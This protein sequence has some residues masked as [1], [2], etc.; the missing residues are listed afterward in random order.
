[1]QYGSVKE[2]SDNPRPLNPPILGDFKRYYSPR[3]GGWG[4]YPNR[5]ESA[6]ARDI[7]IQSMALNAEFVVAINSNIEKLTSDE[8]IPVLADFPTG[9]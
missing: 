8:S 5:I 9:I 2:F 1:M 7:I 4:A 3:I 6:V